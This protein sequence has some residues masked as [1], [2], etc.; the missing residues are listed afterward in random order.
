LAQE[1]KLTHTDSRK[2][3]KVSKLYCY[4]DETGQDTCGRL[5]VVGAV[6]L[7][8]NQDSARAVLVRIEAESRKGQRK[9]AK[10]ARD[11]KREYLDRILLRDEFRLFFSCYRN[12]TAYQVAMTRTCAKA[13]EIAAP[14]NDYHVN[15]FIDGLSRNDQ[16]TVAAGLH[17]WGIPV[18][19]VRGLRDESDEI[20]RLADALAGFTREYVEGRSYVTWYHD[21]AI[22]RGLLEEIP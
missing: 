17:G 8:A 13:I 5:F 14:S 6:I 12:T 19:K 3:Q 15:V 11:Q 7:R 4:A 20:I 18:K 2:T 21:E 16:R 10:S 9:W 22:G 1:D